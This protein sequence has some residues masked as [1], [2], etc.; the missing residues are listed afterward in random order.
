MVNPAKTRSVARTG[1]AALIAAVVSRSRARCRLNSRRLGLLG[2]VSVFLSVFRSIIP[3]TR[4]RRPIIYRRAPIHHRPLD[5]PLFMAP[6]PRCE[7][8]QLPIRRYLYATASL[9]RCFRAAV[10]RIPDNAGSGG[11]GTQV[12]GTACRDPDGQWLILN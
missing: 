5:P 8:P 2:L 11:H 10:P 9:D 6:R 4:R 3:P 1:A 12:Y 7:L